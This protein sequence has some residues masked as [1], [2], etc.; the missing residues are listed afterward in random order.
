[1]KL[2][3]RAPTNRTSAL[4]Q[5]VLW[6]PKQMGQPGEDDECLPGSGKGTCDCSF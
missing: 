4:L 5:S 1:M 6:L 3:Y 2:L